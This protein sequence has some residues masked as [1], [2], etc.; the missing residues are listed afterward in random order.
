MSSIGIL[1]SIDISAT[2]LSAMRRRMNAISSNI[3]NAET[4][5]T[6]EG[7]PYRRREV[8]MVEGEKFPGFP[9][10]FEQQRG[11]LAVTNPRHLQDRSERIPDD[12]QRLHGVD[13][14]LEIS[15]DDPILVF[16]PSHPDADEAGYVA[17]PNINVVQEMVDLIVASR[18]YEANL[19]VVTS[20]KEMVKKALEI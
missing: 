1:P 12:R 17:M 13:G 10:F 20:D 8:V 19:T 9:F 15:Q 11:R 7:G 3:A 4:T 6:E 14:Q 2:G 18:A 5:R 16:D